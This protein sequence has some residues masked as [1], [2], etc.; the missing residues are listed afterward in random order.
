M[1]TL[2]YST[3]QVDWQIS[4]AGAAGLGQFRGGLV[5]LKRQEAASSNM[6]DLVK[7]FHVPH[8]FFNQFNLDICLI[9]KLDVLLRI[10]GPRD[11]CICFCGSWS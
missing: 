8:I 1:A 2:R 11:L 9:L 7:C 3:V 4:V 5:L 10:E 6:F